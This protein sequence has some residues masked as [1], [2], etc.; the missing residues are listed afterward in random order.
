MNLAVGREVCILSI[1]LWNKS[2]LDRTK[3]LYPKFWIGKRDIDIFSL[4]I[5]LVSQLTDQGELEADLN[6]G[7]AVIYIRQQVMFSDP[8]HFILV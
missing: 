7:S 8:A 1:T 6:N 4:Y 3:I 2:D 5:A